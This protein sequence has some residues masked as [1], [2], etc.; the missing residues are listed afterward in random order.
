MGLPKQTEPRT[1][2]PGPRRPPTPAMGTE[3]HAEGH[4]RYLTG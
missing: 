4:G 3:L 1:Q 2:E